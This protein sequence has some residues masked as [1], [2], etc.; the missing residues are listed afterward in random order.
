MDRVP[1]VLPVL[2]VAEARSISPKRDAKDT[3]VSCGRLDLA[4]GLAMPFEGM[5]VPP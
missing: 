2:V 1:M 3:V 5:R 4:G